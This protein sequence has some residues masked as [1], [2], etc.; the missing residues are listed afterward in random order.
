M[1]LEDNLIFDDGLDEVPVLERECRD[2]ITKMLDKVE[3][4]TATDKDPTNLVGKFE[5]T[6]E[7]SGKVIFKSMLVFRLNGNPF[8]SKDR[9][10]Q[11]RNSIYF[12]N[13]EDYLNVANLSSSCLL[14]LGS[15]C[16]VNFVQKSSMN[17]TS[18]VQIACK[19]SR[20]SSSWLEDPTNVSTSIDSGS[21]WIGRVQKMS[22]RAGRK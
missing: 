15:D 12:N 16:G 17:T 2:A 20:N 8:L 13:G 10:I 4:P 1:H 5:P 9:L 7:C 11:I 19:R 21:W 22:R 14:S 3:L 6:V 18:T